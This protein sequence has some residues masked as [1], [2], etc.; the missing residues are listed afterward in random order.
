V[1]PEPVEPAA[2]SP[3]PTPEQTAA[4]PAEA[5]AAPAPSDAPPAP[6]TGAAP[7]SEPATAAATPEPAA[8]AAE[9]TPT[10]PTKPDWLN[11]ASEAAKSSAAAQPVPPRLS[12]ENVAASVLGAGVMLGAFLAIYASGVFSTADQGTAQRDQIAG[13]EKQVRDLA[14]RPLSI[15]PPD[16]SRQI[17]DLDARVAKVEAAATAPRPPQSDPAVPE[18]K[19]QLEAAITAARDAKAR[20]DAAYDAAQKSARA[21]A[22]PPSNAK[23]VTELGTRI[24][25]LEKAQRAAEADR[26][27]RLAFVS[28]ALR[29]VVERGEPFARELDAIR[30]LVSDAKALTPLE[31]FAAAGVP[32]NAQLARELSALT[33]AMLSA[34]GSPPREGGGFMERLQQNAERLVRIRPISETPGDDPATIVSRAEVKAANGNIPGSVAEVASLPVAAR[35]PADAWIKRAEAQQAALAAARNLAEGAVAALTK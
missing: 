14:G 21:A 8:V 12:W 9:S 22:A 5:E 30:P 4:A 17:A 34:A 3:G 25:S 13:L 26:P 31:P 20:A 24:A 32:R 16:S 35:A 28:G 33:G 18:L 15:A 11:V 19:A 1:K 29:A 7:E 27:L 6:D 23:E 10:E 2:E